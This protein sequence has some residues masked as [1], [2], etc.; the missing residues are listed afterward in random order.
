[1]N[2][3]IANLII[4]DLRILRLQ[5]FKARNGVR[6]ILTLTLSPLGRG[7]GNFRQVHNSPKLG[8]CRLNG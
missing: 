4:S 5:G 1:M 3:K 2:L 7:E 6:R 8:H